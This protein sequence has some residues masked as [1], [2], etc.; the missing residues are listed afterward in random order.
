MSLVLICW[1]IEK[2]VG[3]SFPG[4]YHSSS[5]VT[6]LALVRVHTIEL[7]QVGIEG[8]VSTSYLDQEATLGTRV[9]SEQFS[10]VR[11]RERLIYFLH[12]WPSW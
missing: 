12:S 5:C 9:T 2:E 7:V 1:A 3:D 10:E 8:D 6:G 11:E 4:W